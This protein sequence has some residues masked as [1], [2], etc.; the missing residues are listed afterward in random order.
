[1]NT[2]RKFLEYMK[3][4]GEKK[5]VKA[6]DVA[7]ALDVT[8]R[9]VKAMVYEERAAGSLI[10]NNTTPG[11]YFLPAS[12]EDVFKQRERMEQGIKKR[13]LALRPFREYCRK[14]KG[15][16]VQKKM[17]PEDLFLPHDEE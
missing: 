7:K 8:S 1:M 16:G 2:V 13:A 4:Y 5:A 17:E 9:H 6:T 14:W 3:A 12:P 10:C 11:G 15:K